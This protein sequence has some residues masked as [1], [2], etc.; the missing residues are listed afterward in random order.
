MHVLARAQSEPT[1]AAP[2]GLH[3]SGQP[4]VLPLCVSHALCRRDAFTKVKISITIDT[5]GPMRE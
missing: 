4:L 2:L 5:D 1:Q 3:P